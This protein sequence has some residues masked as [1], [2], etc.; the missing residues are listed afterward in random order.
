MTVELISRKSWGAREARGSYGRLS[1]T[2]GVKVHYTG[3]HVDPATLTDHDRCVAAMRGIQ[4]GHMDGNGWIDVGYTALVCSHRKVFVGRG[5]GHVPAANGP[6]FN[7]GHYAVLGLVGTS[8]VTEPPAAMLHGIRD[9]IEWLRDK[10]GAG[11]EIKG[12]RDGY[13]TSCPGGPLYAWVKR[14]APR[15]KE[16]NPAKPAPVR[17]V[18][19][20]GVPEFPGR[21]LQITDPY[22]EGEDVRAWQQKMK[23]RGWTIEVDEVFGP[24]SAAVAA[25][26]RRK[27]G[28]SDRP[29]VD[30]AGWDM[31]WSWRPPAS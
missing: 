12:H 6:G 21:V 23:N 20:D 30:R 18:W 24:K 17:I 28:L 27:T 1:A 22:M 15:P 9:A 5:P 19:K 16:V 2:R 13:A 10:G 3:G 4:R 14:G 29:L 7:S 26:F 11:D 31:T 25:G 8:G